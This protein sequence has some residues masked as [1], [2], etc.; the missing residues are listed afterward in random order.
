[1]A[2]ISRRAARPERKGG[3][4]N[5][6]FAVAPA[7]SPPS[8][9]LA[10][11]DLVTVTLPWGSLLRGVV[12]LDDEVTGGLAA[13]ARPGASIVAL[14]AP[15]ERD[16]A[17]VGERIDPT[18]HRRRIEEA[19]ERVDAELVSVRPATAQELAASGSTWAKRL[20]LTGRAA[21]RSAWRLEARRCR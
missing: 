3:L 13:L 17:A 10:R 1:M 2:E 21:D 8:E 12:G 19:W 4:P 11:A 16:V 20:G 6:L 15:S 5:A 14:I 9:L 18:T 7:E